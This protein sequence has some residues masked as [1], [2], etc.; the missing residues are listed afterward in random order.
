MTSR[1]VRSLLDAAPQHSS[2]LGSITRLTAED[3]PLLTGFTPSDPLV[4]PRTNP[5]DPVE[6]PES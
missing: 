3:F 2:E 1:H 4:A 6:D 5:V